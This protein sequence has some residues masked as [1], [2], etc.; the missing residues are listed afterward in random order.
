MARA[1]PGPDARRRG[2]E[3]YRAD[4]D[5]FFGFDLAHSFPTTWPEPGTSSSRSS[6][7]RR[8]F[9]RPGIFLAPM[10]SGREPKHQGK[11]TFALLGRSRSSSFGSLIGALG[12]HGCSDRPRTGSGCRAASTSTS[13][14]SGRCCSRSASS[15][16]C[17]CSGGLRQRLA[18]E[19][20]GNMPWLF[21]FAGLRD[22]G[23][24]R[25]RPDRAARRQLH[26]RPS[27]GGSGSFTSGLRTSSSCSRR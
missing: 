13:P 1:L 6:G 16:G 3:H 27:S 15:S 20:R 7:P 10:I 25:G 19:H 14:G 23:L 22:P 2:L 21:F 12:I 11:L 17:S 4:I 18:G 24:L 8:H 26:G 9:S 5:D